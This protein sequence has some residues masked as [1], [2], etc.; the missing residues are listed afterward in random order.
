ML[1]ALS[2]AAI[3][4][5]LRGSVKD[6]D[7]PDRRQPANDKHLNEIVTFPVTVDESL[8]AEAQNIVNR[9]C[10]DSISSFK[11]EPLLRK[12]QSKIWISVKAAAYGIAFHAIIMGLPSAELGPV[13]HIAAALHG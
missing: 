10:G 5:S 4:S 13:T 2:T 9:S 11:V 1:Q 8:S 7:P 3:P 12:H 6:D